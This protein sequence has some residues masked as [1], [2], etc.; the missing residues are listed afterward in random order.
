MDASF[1]IVTS[2]LDSQMQD[3]NAKK[4]QNSRKRIRYGLKVWLFELLLADVDWMYGHTN[5]SWHNYNYRLDV[6]LYKFLL[7]YDYRLD[8]GL[9]KFLLAYDYRLDVGLY[10]FLLAYNYRLDVGLYKFILSY[11]GQMFGYND[12]Y[13]LA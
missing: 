6:G 5:F 7:A 1:R 4:E 12:E 13:L 2:I 10:K 8:V 3:K 9:Y 11:M